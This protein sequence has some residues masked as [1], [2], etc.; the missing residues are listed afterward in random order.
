MVDACKCGNE[1]LGSIN[2]RN[3]QLAGNQLASQ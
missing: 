2:V 1:S 3:S